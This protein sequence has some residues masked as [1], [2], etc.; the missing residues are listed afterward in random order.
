MKENKTTTE[1]KNSSIAHHIKSTLITKEEVS[2]KFNLIEKSLQ[3]VEGKLQN[4]LQSLKDDLMS[5]DISDNTPTTSD[6]VSGN[7]TDFNHSRQ[8][9]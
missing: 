3:D 7:N 9:R 2:L 1:E 4:E 6:K 8:P 5:V